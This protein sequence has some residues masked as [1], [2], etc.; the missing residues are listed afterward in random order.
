ME[1]LAFLPIIFIGIVIS[2]V[3]TVAKAAGGK[4]SGT[5]GRT[6]TGYQ[7]PRTPE[8]RRS[9]AYP[10]PQQARRTYASNRVTPTYL[11]G[12]VAGH[13]G[14]EGS[15]HEMSLRPDGVDM[16]KT[17]DDYSRAQLR[18]G[19]RF[20]RPLSADQAE[21][22]ERSLNEL[23]KAGIIDRSEYTYKLEEMGQ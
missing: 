2:I 5:T 23:Y 6:S 21:K 14:E 7:A 4:K 10:L 9:Q 13:M 17:I 15:I 12:T 22:W 20:E 18:N 3:G 16:I 1:F 11:G 8:Q 19:T